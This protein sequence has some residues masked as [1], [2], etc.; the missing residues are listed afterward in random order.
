MKRILTLSL[1]LYAVSIASGATTVSIK[2]TQWYINGDI[3]YPGTPAEGLLM[4][5]RMVNST[6]ED[7]K[8]TDFDSD[9]NAGRFI[10]KIPEYNAYGVRAFTLNLQ[11]GFPGYEGAINSAFNPNGTL[12]PDYMSRIQ[13]VIELCDKQGIVVILG[14]FYQRQDQILRDEEAVKRGL[15]HAVNCIRENGLT[16][17][18]I[19]IANE[20][21]HNGFDHAVI[22]TVEGEIELIRLAK[23]TAPDLLVSTSGLG[24]GRMDDRIAKEADFILIHFNGTKVEDI[25]KRINALKKFNKPI[26]CN[27]DDKIGQEAARALRACVENGCSWGFMSNQ[28][29]QYDPFEFKGYHDDPTVYDTFKEVTVKLEVSGWCLNQILRFHPSMV[30]TVFSS[31]GG[32]TALMVL[33]SFGR[34]LM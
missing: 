21:D 17:V 26:V 2:G 9:E 34:R 20:Y 27:E 23:K 16:N 13:R 31:V 24:H 29:N 33:V 28:L 18:A 25:P 10:S 4:N 30:K 7:R 15:V 14:L 19:E 22:K 11:G 1:L 5:V 3:T 32:N 8:R 12:R 6:F